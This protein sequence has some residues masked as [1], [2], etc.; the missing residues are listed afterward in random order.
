MTSTVLF[1]TFEAAKKLEGAG[2]NPTQ[3]EVLVKT[4][5]HAV[6]ENVATKA[7][8]KELSVAFNALSATT[9]ADQAILKRDLIIWLGG[10]VIT[11]ITIAA[12]VVVTILKDFIAPLVS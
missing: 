7:D 8:L 3:T 2:F 9:K 10:I 6:N 5:H 4:I 11:A 1:D 12:G